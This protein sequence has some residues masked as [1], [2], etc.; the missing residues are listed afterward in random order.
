MTTP[1]GTWRKFPA[2]F[3]TVCRDSDL[4]R[5]GRDRF[6]KRV[7]PT[8][9]RRGQANRNDSESPKAQHAARPEK[10]RAWP[11]AQTC[12]REDS[13]ASASAGFFRKR[14]FAGSNSR[15]D[16][17]AHRPRP[18]VAAV[19]GPVRS[20]PLLDR[21]CR[22]DF[23]ILLVM[24]RILWSQ[25]CSRLSIAARNSWLNRCSLFVIVPRSDQHKGNGLGGV[26][27]LAKHLQGVFER[28][29]ASRIDF[30]MQAP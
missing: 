2:P 7:T 24:P 10:W 11:T 21:R 12:F 27:V 6:S 9:E 23:E 13:A 28:L 29:A 14:N 30:A 5:R 15:C 4:T 26:I 3:A 19:T 18:A 16:G 22:F 25:L 1:S 20:Y 17:P 8:R